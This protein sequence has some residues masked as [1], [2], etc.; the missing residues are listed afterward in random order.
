MVL[1][2]HETP[3]DVLRQLSA[4][5]YEFLAQASPAERAGFIVMP[6][7]QRW[8]VL[9]MHQLYTKHLTVREQRVWDRCEWDRRVEWLMT[10][11]TRRSLADT[12]RSIFDGM[13]ERERSLF[14]R[15]LPPWQQT[16][17]PADPVQLGPFWEEV[18]LALS[19]EWRLMLDAFLEREA[20]AAPD[21]P[22]APREA[23]DSPE[24]AQE[25]PRAPFGP[26]ATPGRPFSRWLDGLTEN[27][28]RAS[29]ELVRVLLLR[30]L[31]AVIQM[32]AWSSLELDAWLELSPEE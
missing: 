14:L 9:H 3:R 25:P 24:W 23:Q 26:A 16:A 11:M 5:E 20:Q 28:V 21:M 32:A 7:N 22:L 19:S 8:L 29:G 13:T 10:E 27:D 18:L 12:E 17:T 2:D 31:G 6:P 15:P 4:R 1:V 30:W